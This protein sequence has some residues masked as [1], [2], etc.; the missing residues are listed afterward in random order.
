MS[1]SELNQIL[2]NGQAESAPPNRRERRSAR[3]ALADAFFGRNANACIFIDTLNRAWRSDI[4]A[5]VL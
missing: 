1:P 5:A 3:M 2:A 4:R